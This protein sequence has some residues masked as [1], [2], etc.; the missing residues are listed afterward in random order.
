VLSIQMALAW[1]AN[2]S[3]GIIQGLLKNE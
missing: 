2:G 1:V 3:T